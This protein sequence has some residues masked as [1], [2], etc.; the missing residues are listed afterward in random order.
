MP[1][2][3]PDDAVGA[4]VAD[5]LDSIE[6]GTPLPSKS[7]LSR[8]ELAE[9]TTIIDAL[10]DGGADDDV[11]VPPLDERAFAIARG[12]ARTPPAVVVDGAAVR[13]AREEASLTEQDVAAAMSDGGFT[14]DAR[15]VSSIERN[16][17]TALSAREARRLAATVGVDVPA[18]E[19]RCEPWLTELVT[20]EAAE[21][22]AR[23]EQR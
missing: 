2:N 21:R 12:I 10:S 9:A 6:S 13:R 11:I 18:I 17:A 1:A 7:R 23:Q 19:T 4:Y 16:D 3:E 14:T 5:Y 15:R 22:R 8:E 20:R